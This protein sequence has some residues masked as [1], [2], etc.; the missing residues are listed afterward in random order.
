MYVETLL[1]HQ[2]ETLIKVLEID[3]IPKQFV[4]GRKY[5][6]CWA[7]SKGIVWILQGVYN[8]QA[9]LITP[10]TK[11]KIQTHINNLREL[12]KFSL[13]NAKK[14]INNKQTI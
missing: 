10:K 5:H 6:C 3:T 8:N 13:E 12:N 7:N 1:E 4:I 11:R 2:V 14:R 9:D